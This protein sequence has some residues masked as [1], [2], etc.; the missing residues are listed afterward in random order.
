MTSDGPTPP[1]HDPVL[2]DDQ[3]LDALRRGEQPPEDDPVAGLLAGWHADVETRAALLDAATAGPGRGPEEQ[4]AGAD[5]APAPRR[6]STGGRR[7]SA[8]PATAGT[9]RD[10]ERPRAGRTT[11][12]PARVLAGAALSLVTVAGGLWLGA[13]R[14]EPG[15]LLWPV[16][17][18]VW[19]ERAETLVT[20][21]EIGRSLEQARDDLA[22]GR[23]ADARARL[24][25]AVALLARLRD[26]EHVARLR[27]DIDGLRHRL[28]VAD[29][30]TPATRT[31]A[32]DDAEPS[33]PSAPAPPPEAPSGPPPTAQQ[34]VEDPA[35][36]LPS[37]VD[38]SAERTQR[39]APARP[40]RPARPAPAPARPA[41]GGTT[42]PSGGQ[43]ERKP[44]ATDRL[45]PAA[46]DGAAPAESSR[47]STPPTPS[48]SAADRP[49]TGRAGSP[50][51]RRA[52]GH[53][54]TRTSSPADRPAAD[55][56]AADTSGPGPRTAGRSGPEP[57]PPARPADAPVPAA[58]ADAATEAG[59]IASDDA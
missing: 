25:R 37:I 57:H 45:P 59:G 23:Y 32:P 29:A 36:E 3:L 47:R 56:A 34:V 28:P 52:A 12:R 11:R 17:E 4:P 18:L 31:P 1:P 55:G 13:A 14:A 10:P 42:P 2:R 54:V 7:R 39:T 5:P 58:T 19:T 48:G 40:Q 41:P 6:G 43:P 27:A 21:Q 30:P 38:P 46:S 8:V 9:A 49:A 35:A 22:A 20:E 15:G 51:D 50:S 33:P 16:T 53:A 44:P 24:E 26:S